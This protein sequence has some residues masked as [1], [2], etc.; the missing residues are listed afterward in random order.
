MNL[1]GGNIRIVSAMSRGLRIMYN[2]RVKQIMYSKQDVAVRTAM[3]VFKGISMSILLES[4][5][6]CSKAHAL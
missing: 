4:R 5:S 3:H 1:A 2:S 6:T